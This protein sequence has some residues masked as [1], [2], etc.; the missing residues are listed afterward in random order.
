MRS[1]ITFTTGLFLLIGSSLCCATEDET[2]IV[3][4]SKAADWSYSV[5]AYGYFVPD[6][7]SYLSAIFTTD[8]DWLHLEGRYNYE[9]LDTGSLFFGR[10]FQTGK[11]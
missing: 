8:H 9:N 5:S 2:P 4:D 7:Q 6:D 11:K 3:S 1:F 10:N